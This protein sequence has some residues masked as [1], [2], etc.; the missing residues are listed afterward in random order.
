MPNYLASI[1]VDEVIDALAAFIKQFIPTEALVIR[2]EVNRV[3]P[4]CA[5]YVELTEILQVDLN[6]PYGQFEGI[7]QIADIEASTRIDIQVDFYGSD[8]GDFC[9]AF[10]SA[11]RT[12]WGYDQFPDNIKPL[13][14]D[15]GRQMPLITGEKQYERRWTLTASL[16]YNPVVT[17]PQQS[18]LQVDAIIKFPVT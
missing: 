1:T 3:A 9:K 12:E 7:A 4:P 10:K 6:M 13:Y 11:F 16:Q 17:V 8:G 18:A 5:P 2:G 15:D 14:S